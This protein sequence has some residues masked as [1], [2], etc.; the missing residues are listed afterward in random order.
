MKNHLVIGNKNYSS[1]SLRPWLLLKVKDIPFEEEK[2]YLYRPD[3]KQK[4]KQYSPAGLVPFFQNSEVKVWDSLAICEYLAEAYP[5]KH[6][7]P[8]ELQA[9]ALARSISAE[10]HSGFQLIRNQLPMNCRQKMNFQVDS[11]EL[12]M[13]INRVNSIWQDC[14]MHYQDKGDFL[15]GEFSIAD[16]MFAPVVLRFNSYGI[17]VGSVA[18]QYMQN[19]LNLKAIQEWIEEGIAEKPVIE[20]A[21]I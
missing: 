13:E 18:R 17:E 14:R 3:S 12:R 21:E 7:W 4:L 8:Q 19:I 16:A 2:I 15:F 6:C 1:W 5:E 20:Q 11:D 10:M 9:R